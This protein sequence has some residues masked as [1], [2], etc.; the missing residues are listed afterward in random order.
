MTNQKTP[1]FEFIEHE[2]PVVCDYCHR[3]VTFL[4]SVTETRTYLDGDHCKECFHKKKPEFTEALA[5]FT[6]LLVILEEMQNQ[7]MGLNDM[8]E[9]YG[10][11]EEEEDDEALR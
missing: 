2:G 3:E 9:L 7:K 10:N 8:Y 4:V 11:P 5:N 1:E 6:D